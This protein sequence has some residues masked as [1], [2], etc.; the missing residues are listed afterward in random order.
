MTLEIQ[1]DLEAIKQHYNRLL[2][3]VV[4]FKAFSE[5][6]VLLATNQ[7]DQTNFQLQSRELDPDRVFLRI[8]HTAADASF[9]P[10]AIYCRWVYID[11]QGERYQSE[12][13]SNFEEMIQIDRLLTE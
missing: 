5:I 2:S 13:W 11:F 3:T 7:L 10:Q 4:H 8:L 9:D 12:S 1:R 6:E